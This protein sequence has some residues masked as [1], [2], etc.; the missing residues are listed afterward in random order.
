VIFLIAGVTALIGA[1]LSLVLIRARDLHLDAQEES[2]SWPEPDT[3][4]HGEQP[5]LAA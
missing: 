2:G 4:D 1:A 5:A 3:D